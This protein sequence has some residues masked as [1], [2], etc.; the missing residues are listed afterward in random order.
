MYGWI[1][2]ILKSSF[3]FNGMKMYSNK[4]IFNIN[5]KEYIKC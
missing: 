2:A 5:K 3:D 4:I 1:V